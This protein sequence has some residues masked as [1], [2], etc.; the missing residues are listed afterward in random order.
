MAKHIHVFGNGRWRP[1]S[2]FMGRREEK[3]QTLTLSLFLLEGREPP[4]PLNLKARKAV[5]VFWPPFP[6]YARAFFPVVRC[7]FWRKFPQSRPCTTRIWACT[8]GWRLALYLCSPSPALGL[9]VVAYLLEDRNL[10]K[11]RSL[12]SS[13]PLV[14]EPTCSKCYDRKAKI[15]PRTSK[16]CNR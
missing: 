12:D 6:L 14:N 7:F 13:C 9:R 3:L 16:D 5:A 4:P 8:T 10:L 15:A 2:C 1:S 11:L